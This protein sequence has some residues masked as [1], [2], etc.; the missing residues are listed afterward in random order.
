MR[1]SSRHVVIAIV[2]SNTRDELTSIRTL[3][4]TAVSTRN[5]MA[6]SM[7][8]TR[9]PMLVAAVRGGRALNSWLFSSN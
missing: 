6:W 3:A 5:F 2:V 8:H 9:A 4:T 1:Q 7:T